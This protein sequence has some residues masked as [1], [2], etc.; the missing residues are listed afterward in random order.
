M[1]PRTATSLEIGALVSSEIPAAAGVLARGMRDNPNHVAIFGSDPAKRVRAL[2]RGFGRYLRVASAQ[3][4][5]CARLDGI[6]V[7]VAGVLPA[8]RCRLSPIQKLR[9][10]PSM[11]GLTIADMRRASQVTRAW[12]AHDPDEPHS[13]LGPV[14][15]DEGLKSQGL[16]TRLL[17]AYCAQ[18]DEAHLAAY[19]ETETIRNVRFY[20][21]FGFE[22]IGHAE[23][24]GNPNWFMWRLAH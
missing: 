4:P 1:N 24:L 11:A 8:G 18:L 13:H 22:T 20:E 23:V 9:L 19:L 3:A 6:V 14:A 10:V 7:G 12:A 16:G 5:L 15:V 21:R 2:E 17:E